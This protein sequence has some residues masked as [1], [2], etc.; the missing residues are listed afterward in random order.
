ME[1]PTH[2]QVEPPPLDAQLIEEPAPVPV[3]SIP[4]ERPVAVPKPKPLPRMRPQQAAAAPQVSPPVEQTPAAPKA[5]PTT[6]T[7]LSVLTA[8]PGSAATPGEGQ[9]AAGGSPPA[10]SAAQAGPYEGKGLS[11]RPYDGKGPSRVGAAYLDNPRPVYPPAAKKMGMEGLVMLK[12]LVSREG[13]VLELEVAQ[14]SGYKILD[15]AAKEA[16]KSWRFAPTRLGDSAVD[17]WVQVPMA[18]RLKK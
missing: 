13:N 11:A 7:G 3:Q 8:A 15:S 1:K 9:V 2:L 17:E 10:S 12:V 4:Q 6:D 5:E 14:S 16:V 18:F